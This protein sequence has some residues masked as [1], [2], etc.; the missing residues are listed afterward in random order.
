MKKALLVLT[1]DASG[2][3]VENEEEFW[4]YD[5]VL[6]A[7]TKN[8][9]DKRYFKNRNIKLINPPQFKKDLD[10]VIE[11]FCCVFS[12]L[13]IKYTRVELINIFKSKSN[14]YRKF[15]RLLK[16]YRTSKIL[17]KNLSK[18]L[19]K[20]IDY[21]FTIYSYW[22]DENAFA[23]IQLKKRFG[24]KTFFRCHRFDL[25]LEQNKLKYLPLREYLVKN[26]DGIFPCSQDGTEYL[27]KHYP[28]A[29]EKIITSYLG[30]LDYGQRKISENSI[31]S[32]ATCS[33]IVDV[34]RL[35]RMVEFLN[36]LEIENIRWIH[37]GDG[38]LREEIEILTKK[39]L[40][41]KI[42]FVFKGQLPNAKIMDYYKNNDIH[43][44]MNV[45]ESEGLP[46]SIMEAISFGIP[47]IATD[48]GGTN[49]IVNVQTGMVLSKDFTNLEAVNKVSIIYDMY[50]YDYTNYVKLR[51]SARKFWYENFHAEENY[52]KFIKMIKGL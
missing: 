5:L 34:K 21:E 28:F 19:A 15:L 7:P 9:L 42:E 16:F 46:V 27:N 24:Y 37:F 40:T 50:K 41:N 18:E 39:L 3:F 17:N 48:V 26:C 4:D 47:I 31:F 30:T 10:L 45:S 11:Y 23:S 44:F 51:N 33:Y 1:R 32:I 29:K 35:N 6:F 12:M 8:N 49:E 38:I 20:Y 13:L 22:M 43:L 52:K 25:Y 2:S 36:C 14:R